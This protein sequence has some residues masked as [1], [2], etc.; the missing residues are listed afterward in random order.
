[1]TTQ[2]QEVTL[3]VL[4]SGF[5]IPFD[6]FSS[7]AA[8]RG[9]LVTLN[10]EQVAGTEDRYGV[11]WLSMTEEEQLARWGHVN[12]ALGDQREAECIKFVGEDDLAQ[13][14]LARERAVKHADQISD[15]NE[16]RAAHTAIRER[17]GAPQSTQRTLQSWE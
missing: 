13:I 16:R 4:R 8:Y 6:N 3:T 15:P 2:T 5:T 14:A 10:A 17:F 7:R 12:F 9:E 11:S 1:M